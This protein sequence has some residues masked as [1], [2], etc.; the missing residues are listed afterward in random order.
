MC[1]AHPEHSALPSYKLPLKV[2]IVPANTV[3]KI[4]TRTENHPHQDR[5][6]EETTKHYTKNTTDITKTASLLSRRRLNSPTRPIHLH[7]LNLPAPP[8]PRPL[9]SRSTLLPH[10]IHLATRAP[11]RRQARRGEPR[12]RIAHGVILDHTPG[13]SLMEST[14][15][16]GGIPCFGPTPPPSEKHDETDEREEETCAD[17]AAY[18]SA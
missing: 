5:S 10:L 3:Q 14:S 11:R 18:Y 6:L 9:P 7:N 13:L 12:G 15:R 16:A 4:Q 1:Y 2:G 17:C 8:H